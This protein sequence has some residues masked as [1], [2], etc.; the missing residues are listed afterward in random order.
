LLQTNYKNL[1]HVGL[2]KWWDLDRFS[3][4]SHFLKNV[5]FQKQT[6]QFWV[7]LGILVFLPLIN[8]FWLLNIYQLSGILRIKRVHF[9]V[10]FLVFVKVLSLKFNIL[11][12]P[13][14]ADILRKTKFNFYFEEGFDII[15]HKKLENIETGPNVN[16]P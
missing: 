7:T 4:C 12:R 11:W 3:M 1:S 2:C 9:L 8:I 6:W 15:I 10:A 14:G 13:E 5:L 16:G